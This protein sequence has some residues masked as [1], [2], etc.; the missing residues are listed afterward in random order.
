VEIG[1]MD[2]KRHSRLAPVMISAAVLLPFILLVFY[3]AG[4]FWLS[5][6]REFV[7]NFSGRQ[8]VPVIEGEPADL[9]EIDR[10]FA[11]RWLANLYA[12]AAAAES[13]LR[14]ARATTSSECNKYK[15]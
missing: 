5:E 2:E 7:T 3:V 12:P 10:C 4:Y 6:K 14:G 15:W 8:L 13:L 9:H 11:H 1:G